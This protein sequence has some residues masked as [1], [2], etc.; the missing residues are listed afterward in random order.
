[1]RVIAALNLLDQVILSLLAIRVEDTRSSVAK[2]TDISQLLVTKLIQR[3]DLKC[4]FL[5]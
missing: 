4:D 5:R 3:D 2:F 1:M